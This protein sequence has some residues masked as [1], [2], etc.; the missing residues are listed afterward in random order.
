ME[1]YFENPSA[2]MS[3]RDVLE[4]ASLIAADLR[5]SL[6]AISFICEDYAS[7]NS[8]GNLKAE[9]LRGLMSMMAASARMC[10]AKIDYCVVK[11]AEMEDELHELSR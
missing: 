8:Q 1:A 7:P 11:V 2:G 3:V 9:V 6:D 5:E 10:H 4:S